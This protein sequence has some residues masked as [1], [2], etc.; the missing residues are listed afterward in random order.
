MKFLHTADLH[1]D[2]SQYG[3]DERRKDFYRCF[4]DICD[5]AI[6]QKVD[7]I[8]LAGDLLDNKGP[9]GTSVYTLQQAVNK[10]KE[11]GI[12]V[13]GIVGNHDT[14]DD[15]LH[16]CGIHNLDTQGGITVKGIRFDGLGFK[17][18]TKFKSTLEEDR[19]TRASDVF[20]MHQMVREASISTV[21]IVLEELSPL[22]EAMGVQY[23]AM[24]DVHQKQ[25][26]KFGNVTFAYPGSPERKSSDDSG[27]KTVNIV[28]ITKGE[29]GKLIVSQVSTSARPI[30]VIDISDVDD[31]DKWIKH[32]FENNPLIYV[33]YP[34]ALL[35]QAKNLVNMLSSKGLLVRPQLKNKII[36]DIEA[37]DVTELQ[38]GDTT[39]ILKAVL[40]SYFNPDGCEY[41]LILSLIGGMDPV[42]TVEGFLED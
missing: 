33:K 9:G 41:Q 37:P 31:I 11:A 40:E 36:S 10:A 27:D 24:G 34:G 18:P 30:E 21:P 20:V 29:P 23:V 4:R 35:E 19:E 2:Y 6:S 25:T 7:A 26:W 5:T 3:L 1:L 14:C 28:D 13:M 39:G 12:V 15:W 42:D 32:K 16:L 22:F 8:V 38:T 17:A